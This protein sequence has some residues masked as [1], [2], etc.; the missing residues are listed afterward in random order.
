MSPNDAVASGVILEFLCVLQKGA[1][2]FVYLS[3]LMKI[4]FFSL[5]P[6]LKLNE[7][8]SPKGALDTL[9]VT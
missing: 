4:L 9:E 2:Y 1:L 6:L 5:H 3:T 7:E 8:T